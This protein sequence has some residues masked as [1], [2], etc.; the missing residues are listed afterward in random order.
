MRLPESER[1]KNK[2]ALCHVFRG[3][4]HYQ[5]R[6]AFV[7]VSFYFHRFYLLRSSRRLKKGAVASKSRDEKLRFCI[8]YSPLRQ[9]T[10]SVSAAPFSRSKL[11]GLPLADRH[12]ALMV[13]CSFGHM[14]PRRVLVDFLCRLVL[15]DDVTHVQV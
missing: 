10:C 4:R 11:L 15:G 13:A 14:L 1:A 12:A 2:R 5:I 7:F 9:K 8:L 6:I 3:L